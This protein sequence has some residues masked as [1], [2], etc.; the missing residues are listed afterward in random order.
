MLLRPTDIG[1]YATSNG[2]ES[3]NYADFAYFSYE[4][5]EAPST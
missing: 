5:L 1:L 4:E 3:T 2:Q